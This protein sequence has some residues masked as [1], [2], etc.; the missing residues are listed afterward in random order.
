MEVRGMQRLKFAGVLGA[1]LLLG[2][3]AVAPVAATHVDPEKVLGNPTCEDL[4][5]DPGVKFDPPESGTKDVG[6][7]SVEVEVTA[8][9]VFTWTSEDVT[10]LA[11][12]V[13]GGAET[14]QEG[15]SANVYRYT[16]GE[17]TDDGLH[18]PH[19]FSHIEFCFEDEAE[20]TPAPTPGE[21][22][23]APTPGEETAAPTPG[24]ETAAPTPGEETA[25]PTPTGEV[26]AETAPPSDVDGSGSSTSS[27]SLVFT[28][29]AMIGIAVAL[30]MVAP[31]PASIRKRIK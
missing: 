5:F 6:S 15:P 23:A 14:P 19:G 1:V 16:D 10:I 31:T 12:I 9:G 13:K 22:T 24:E 17:T 4:G 11:V 20:E 8:P 26:L 3:V 28:L 18:A 30:V 29:L 2:L 27:G 7:G 25:A 21:E